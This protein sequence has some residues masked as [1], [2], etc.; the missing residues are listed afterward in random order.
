ME[1]QAKVGGI[2]SIISGA[3][4]VFWLAWILLMFFL[5]RIMPNEAPYPYN[6]E[7]P[8]EFFRMMTIFY[9]VIGGFFVI[10]GILAIIGGIFALKGRKWGL[11]LT[12]AIAGTLTF[13]PCGIPAIIFVSMARQEFVSPKPPATVV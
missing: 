5:M 2:L 7:M 1:S 9:S 6:G 4:G 11:A 3:F 12:G 13:F 8:A 10:L